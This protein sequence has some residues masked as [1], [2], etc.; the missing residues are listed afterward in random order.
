MSATNAS[1]SASIS[2]T[3]TPA[4]ASDF[5]EIKGLGSVK[6]L[7]TQ[8]FPLPS[9]DVLNTQ[10]FSFAISE[11]LYPGFGD[12]GVSIPPGAWPSDIR[13]PPTITVLGK[14]DTAQANKSDSS[15]IVVGPMLD[16]GPSGVSFR[17]PVTIMLPISPPTPG[18]KM[19][20][21]E[22]TGE[23]AALGAA[24]LAKHGA[25]YGK[26]CAAWEDGM[27]TASVKASSGLGAH[28]CAGTNASSCQAHW[29]SYNFTLDQSWC[30][31]AWCYVNSTTC[32]KE[33]QA[34]YG[35]T[36]A[37]S[38]T[39][40]A[41]QYSY[42]VCPDPFSGP[43]GLADVAFSPETYSQYNKSTCPYTK[44]PHPAGASAG[45]TPSINPPPKPAAKIIY[46][47]ARFEPV[48]S[49]WEVKQPSQKC[50]E[51]GVACAATSSFSLYSAVTVR[52][53]NN[54]PIPPAYPGCGGGCI[55][56]IITAVTVLLFVSAFV[57]HRN[58]F[59]RRVKA[60]GQPYDG[61]EMQADV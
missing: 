10:G 36:L 11:D 16:F 39:G 46:T 37:D 47:V 28:T 57:A 9:V 40:K 61:L 53:Y 38:W 49:R 55:A 35:I 45:F 24:E 13:T 1:A 43:T 60:S 56:L 34:K 29:P 26:W 51:G 25:D 58:C 17:K 59:S 54:G 8:G 50:S 15:M 23:N 27:C 12:V 20:G 18:S 41:L 32:T 22:C 31:D 7:Y 2:S 14:V 6:V 52:E 19:P 3:P 21:C 48:G 42:G 5:V 33:L 44:A 4:T 30:C